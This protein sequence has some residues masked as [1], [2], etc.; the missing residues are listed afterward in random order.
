MNAV[1]DASAMIAFLRKEPG[2]LIVA[3]YLRDVNTR[4]MAHGINLCEVYYDFHRTGGESK[5]GEAIND[6]KTLGISGRDDF[7][8]VFWREVGKLK[9]TYRK[10]SLADCCGIALTNR[11]GGE[12][13]T[14][15][16]NE[17]DPLA[18]LGVCPIVFIR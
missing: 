10:V 5:A 14:S 9:A 13:I 3:G 12:F 18:A 6:L 15:D 16:H 11:V 8:E 17:L 7:D 2:A 4:C 1:L